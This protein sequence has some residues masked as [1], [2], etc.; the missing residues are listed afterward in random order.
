MTNPAV[1]DQL[2]QLAGDLG[3]TFIAGALGPPMDGRLWIADH[4][5][6]EVLLPDGQPC[7][8]TLLIAPGGPPENQV[9]VGRGRLDAQGLQRLRKIVSATHAALY[10]GRLAHL[11]PTDWL[12]LHASPPPPQG[13]LNDPDAAAAARPNSGNSEMRGFDDDAVIRQAKAAGWP[14]NVGNYRTLFLDDQP[15]YHLLAKENTGRNVILVV[16]RVGDA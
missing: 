5:L 2:H 6:D 4:A 12:A 8:A 16:G 15:L 7:V 10:E 14:A 3:L 1:Y 9:S 11:S 13:T